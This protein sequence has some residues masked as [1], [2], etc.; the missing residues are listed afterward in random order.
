MVES[1]TLDLLCISISQYDLI[2]TWFDCDDADDA[3]TLRLHIKEK[4][5]ARHEWAD[6]EEECRIALCL[7]LELQPSQVEPLS[8]GNYGYGY[9]FK[10]GGAEYWVCS[11]DD[12][13]SAWDESLDNYIDECLE[14]P[15]LL[16]RYFDR[17][18]WKRDA[19]HDGRAHSL[20]TY[21]GEELNAMVNGTI[22]CIYRIN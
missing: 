15:E 13:D 22:Y 7:E 5:I 8:D 2:K 10:A 4:F 14:L 16:E 21:D 20:N 11:D 12:A 9:S 3:E 6:D 1:S 18:S 19:R 17:E